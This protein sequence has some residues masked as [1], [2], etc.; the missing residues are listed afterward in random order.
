MEER[1]KRAKS[2][3]LGVTKTKCTIYWSQGYGR[4]TLAEFA[5]NSGG[6]LNTWRTYV[7]NGLS[8]RYWKTFTKMEGSKNWKNNIIFIFYQKYEN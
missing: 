2:A 3:Y 1:V 4:K 7:L 8:L 6:H 5:F